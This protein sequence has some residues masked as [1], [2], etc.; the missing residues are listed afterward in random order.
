[1]IFKC[2]IFVTI[3]FFACHIL[4]SNE[5]F[6]S[7]IQ[8]CHYNMCHFRACLYGGARSGCQASSCRSVRRRRVGQPSR[9]YSHRRSPDGAFAVILFML[10]L[11]LG[12]PQ[13]ITL[14]LKPTAAWVAVAR[15][16][17]RTVQL[18]L[19]TF[20]ILRQQT[21]GSLSF[22][23]I[24]PTFQMQGFPITSQPRQSMEITKIT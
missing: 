8:L 23:L 9:W 2:V 3:Y 20:N 22:E 6:S 24:T 14:I 16:T 18:T 21:I 12:G 19:R 17:S 13:Q 1:M 10:I 15:T 7:L 11:F 4:Y 5:Y